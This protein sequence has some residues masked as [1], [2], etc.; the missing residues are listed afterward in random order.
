MKRMNVI[1]CI[2]IGM[3]MGFSLSEM[4]TTAHAEIEKRASSGLKQKV[5]Y[6][7]IKQAIKDVLKPSSINSIQDIDDVKEFLRKVQTALKAVIP[8]QHQ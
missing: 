1:L 4:N 7:K 3:I 2:A 6:K 8:K 5:E